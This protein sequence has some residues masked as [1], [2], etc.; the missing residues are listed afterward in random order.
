MFED[1]LNKKVVVDAKG[2]FVFL[3]TLKKIHPNW[4][5][6]KKVDVHDIHD[7]SSTKENYIRKSRKTGFFPNRN[8]CRIDRDQIISI[9]LFSDIIP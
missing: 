2:P 5:E 7:T 6:L 4:I 3:G 1:F 8:S 9:S